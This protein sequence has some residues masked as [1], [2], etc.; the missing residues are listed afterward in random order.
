MDK[1][2]LSGAYAQYK[3]KQAKLTT[4]LKETAD[5]CTTMQTPKPQKYK[6]LSSEYTV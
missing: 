1:L 2:T 5:K 3:S 6:P 4:W